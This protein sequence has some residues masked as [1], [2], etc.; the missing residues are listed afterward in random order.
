MTFLFEVY[1]M[2]DVFIV[3]YC[4]FCVLL[5]CLLSISQRESYCWWTKSCTTKDDDYPIIYRV[6]TIPG[7]AGF[8]PSTVFPFLPGVFHKTV[9]KLLGFHKAKARLKVGPS[10]MMKNRDI[11]VPRKLGVFSTSEKWQERDSLQG[12]NPYPPKMAFW[13]DDFPNFPFG[14]IC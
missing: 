14:G 9:K 6:L 3:F 7:G 5:L 4:P 13:V 1:Q 8:C 12:T 10:K 11:R 2:G